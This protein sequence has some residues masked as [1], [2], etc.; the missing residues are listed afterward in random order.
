MKT[1][2]YL[3]TELLSPFVRAYRIIESGDEITNRVLPGTSLTIAFR[4]RGN[5]SYLSDN[6]K[7][8]LPVSTISGLRKSVRL[9]NYM[10]G[11]ATLIVLFRETGAR[12]FF[13]EPLYELFEKSVPLGNFIPSPRLAII[14]EQLAGAENNLQRIAIIEQFLLSRLYNYPADPLI[15]SALETIHAAKG[16]IKIKKLADTL[17]I[18]NDAFE[19][20]FRNAVGTAAKQFSFIVRMEA[21]AKQ[22][23]PAENFNDLA[24]RAGF[25]DAPHFNKEFKLFTGLTPKAFFKNPSFW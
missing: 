18:S 8:N 17:Y 9:I 6:T 23:Q 21:V 7:D 22:K 24:F 4:F 20:R 13:K 3:P 15:A 2:E 11:A 10:P 14:E 25:Y 16:I 19:K 12:A 1:S 5:V